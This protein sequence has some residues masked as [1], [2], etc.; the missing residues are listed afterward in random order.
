MTK[1]ISRRE[2][3]KVGALGVLG[4]LAACSP[5]AQATEALLPAASPFPTNTSAPP[6]TSVPGTT[7][8]DGPTIT[9]LISDIASHIARYL[10]S[11]DESQRIKTSYAFND[12]EFTRWHWTTPGNFPRNGLPL[13]EMQ[14]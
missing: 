4:G 8:T 5:A 6:A 14:A 13:R 1:K 12:P 9:T 10:E 7:P 3:L 2:V 11:L